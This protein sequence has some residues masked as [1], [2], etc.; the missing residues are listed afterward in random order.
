MSLLCL[1][2]YLQQEHTRKSTVLN[3][4][5]GCGFF[6][7]FLLTVPLLVAT[8]YHEA[9]AKAFNRKPAT[10]AN[11]RSASCKGSPQTF[12]VRSTEGRKTIGYGVFSIAPNSIYSKLGI[13]EHDDL[14][15]INGHE[16]NRP[17][18]KLEIEQILG[19]ATSFDIHLLRRGQP[20]YIV[21]QLEELVVH[22][23][24]T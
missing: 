19:D 22:L 14:Q 16:L 1:L 10:S 9:E 24:E 8:P 2:S 20:V 18:M 4:V 12:L 7:L 23:G 17:N 11:T 13:E 6:A 15:K 3:K 5:R 21:G